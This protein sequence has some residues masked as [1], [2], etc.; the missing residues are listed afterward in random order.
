MA[1]LS[2]CLIWHGLALIYS[3]YLLLSNIFLLILCFL[4]LHLNLCIFLSMQLIISSIVQVLLQV[5]LDFTVLVT[6]IQLLPPIMNLVHLYLR[7]ICGMLENARLQL[8]SLWILLLINA[9]V[10]FKIV[11][12]LNLVIFAPS[13][14]YLKSSD[15]LHLMKI[16]NFLLNLKHTNAPFFPFNKCFMVVKR[17]LLSIF[18]FYDAN[19]FLKK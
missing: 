6:V 13:A 4:F 10:L 8:M 5:C 11:G 2:D 16:L 3:S 17:Q 12:G 19:L 7:N 9:H 18:I 14:S 15:C 1:A